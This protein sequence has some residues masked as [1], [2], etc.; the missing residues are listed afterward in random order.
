MSLGDETADPTRRK[1]LVE[2]EALVAMVA[3]D[4]LN[5]LGYDVIEVATARAALDCAYPDCAKFDLAVI[6][7]GLPDR[8]GDELIRT[9]ASCVLTC[10]SSWRPAMARANCAAG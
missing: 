3:A 1:L 2:D 5:E 7:M 9:C 4:S 6:D 10:R 8:P